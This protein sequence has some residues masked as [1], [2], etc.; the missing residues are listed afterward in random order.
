[1][2]DKRKTQYGTPHS[3]CVIIYVVYRVKSFLEAHRSCTRPFKNAFSC[4]PRQ[5]FS[6]KRERK[7]WDLKDL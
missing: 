7:S 4:L 5:S 6:P 2:F 3:T 1:M